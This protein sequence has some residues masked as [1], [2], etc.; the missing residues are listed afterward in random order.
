MNTVAIVGRPNVGKSTL[1]NRLIGERKAIVDDQSGVTRDRQY[2]IFDWDGRE[3]TVIDTGGF[4]AKTDDVFEKAIKN[5]VQIAID[6]A[7]IILFVVDVQTGITDLDQ[8]MTKI[9]RKT[10]KPI[11]LVVNKVENP[12]NRQNAVEF[13][14]LGITENFFELSAMT[15]SGTGE[16]LDQIIELLPEDKPKLETDLPK[17]AVLGRPNAGKSSFVNA[18]LGY[19]R[20]V[21]TDIA[22]TT[23][24]TIHTRYNSYGKDFY[25][26]D[27][28]GL[29]K[30]SKVTEN[31]E[32]YSVMRAVKAID[33]ADVIF[34]MIDA[35]RG[36][37]TQDQNIFGLAEKRQKGIVI[38]VNKW[39]L[40]EGKDNHTTQEYSKMIKDKI[41]PFVDVPI[42]FMSALTKQ[43]IFKAIETGIEVYNS[44]EKEIPTSKLNEFLQ[45]AI[46][47][48][49]PPSTKGKYIQI[50]YMTQVKIN[51]PTFTFFANLPQY[52]KD[53]YKR[54]LENEMRDTFDFKGVP[55]NLFFR[56]K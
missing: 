46:N 33:E 48:N 22:G 43:R 5:Q 52:I 15:G 50:K 26:I 10:D 31:I 14:N 37:E 16:L 21:V 3:F 24:D 32:F 28:A 51:P 55:L 39:D 9:L 17:L 41:A 2:G 4:V 34:I 8:D 13:Y 47:K 44:R 7:D 29:R 27:T 20:T 42:I 53:P 12:E 30:K 40:V 1:F 6:E 11:M 56:K 23:R 18:L 36:F 45:F 35:T 54:Y 25:L 49:H 38:L 19:D